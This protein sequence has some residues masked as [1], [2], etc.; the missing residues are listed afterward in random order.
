MRF[1]AVKNET[2][3]KDSSGLCVVTKHNNPIMVKGVMEA[4][5]FVQNSKVVEVYNKITPYTKTVLGHTRFATT[6]QVNMNNAQP[7]RYGPI[8]G[9]H[10]GVIR[11]YL[12]L[13][14]KFQLRN[15]TT[16]DSEII[17]ALLSRKRSLKGM[18]KALGNLNGYWAIA[19]H[20]LDYPNKVYFS[21]GW[22]E[23]SFY[24][25]KDKSYVIWSSDDRVI[26]EAK[27]VFDLKLD[28]IKMEDYSIISI[29]ENGNIEM[30][31]IHVKDRFSTYGGTYKNGVWVY[32]D[33]EV[34]PGVSDDEHNP[35]Y[36]Y[37]GNRIDSETTMFNNANERVDENLKNIVESALQ[38]SKMVDNVECDIC[39]QT[40]PCRFAVKYNAHLCEMCLEHAEYYYKNEC[41]NNNGNILE[42]GTD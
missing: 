16:C 21:L 12:Y 39:Q 40:K 2:R 37:T 26:E 32:G 28:E 23:C 6:G 29:D 11:N 8:I 15:Y 18:A 19:F 9:V 22:H 41:P 38:L 35:A 30:E 27:L 1:M 3:G 14:K 31:Q 25:S 7:F 20:H 34:N 36:G 10:N 13:R 5:K 4:S 24:M 42:Q 17:F 33:G